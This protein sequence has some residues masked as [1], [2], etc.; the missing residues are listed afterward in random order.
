MTINIERATSHDTFAI[1]R[2]MRTIWA[3]E[4]VVTETVQQ[5][6]EAA[7]HVTHI[8]TENDRVVGFVDGFL[9]YSAEN[10]MRWEIDLVA[11]LPDQRGQQIGRQL[12]AASMAAG[13]QKGAD[14]IRA[15]IHIGN[16]ASQHAF[17]NTGFHTLTEPHLLV[18]AGE[19]A[20]PTTVAVADL[21]CV[22]VTTCRYRGI[23]LE[24]P[25]NA[26]GYRGAR[27]LQLRNRYDVAGAVIPQHAGVGA[28][29]VIIG[30]Y[31]WWVK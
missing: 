22:P 27:A 3:E 24:R 18:V 4:S 30:R 1:A 23:W 25:F 19:T 29:W 6:I 7:D 12:I 17:A 20:Q 26:D 11:V 28:G 16:E 21:Y 14:Q 31:E 10:M 2:I 8:A 5:A 9:T 13:K 15:L